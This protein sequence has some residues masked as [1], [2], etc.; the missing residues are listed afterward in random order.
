V[1]DRSSLGGL[2]LCGPHRTSTYAD[3]PACGALNEAHN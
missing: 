2:D 3:S 1:H